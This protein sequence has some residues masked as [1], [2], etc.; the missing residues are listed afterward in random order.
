MHISYTIDFSIDT[1]KNIKIISTAAPTMV[2]FS[3]E[4][5]S[6][7]VVADWSIGGEGGLHYGA[8]DTRG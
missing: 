8:D 6:M 7:R 2:T 3:E 5:R 4:N 1:G